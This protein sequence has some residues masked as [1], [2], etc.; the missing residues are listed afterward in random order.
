MPQPHKH[1][2]VTFQAAVLSQP[3]VEYIV[4]RRED[5]WFI[6]A[7]REEYGPFHSPREAMRR[8]IEAAQQL[9]VSGTQTQVRLTDASGQALHAWTYG[10]DPFPP[11]L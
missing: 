4:R 11:R 3:R 10:I 1:D 2:S 9:G 5:A 6:E 8:A 7:N